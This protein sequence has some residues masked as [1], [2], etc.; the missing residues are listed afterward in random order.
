MR[1]IKLCLYNY[2]SLALV[3]VSFLFIICLGLFFNFL[4]LIVIKEG[5]FLHKTI[6][7]VSILP[8]IMLSSQLSAEILGIVVYGKLSDKLLLKHNHRF[9]ILKFICTKFKNIFER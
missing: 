4:I 2:F 7:F 9:I 3:T 1:K 6:A 8:I 5:S